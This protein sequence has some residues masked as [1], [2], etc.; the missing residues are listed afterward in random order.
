MIAVRIGPKLQTGSDRVPIVLQNPWGTQDA[1]RPT[2]HK[3][4][5]LR[6]RSF[7]R[8]L[9]LGIRKAG[10]EINVRVEGQV[11]LNSMPLVLSAVQAGSCIA[12]IMEDRAKALLEA[13]EAVRVMGSW[14][15]RSMV[16]TF[17]IRAAVSRRLLS[18][19]SS[20]RFATKVDNQKAFHGV[21]LEGGSSVG[22]AAIC[23]S[24]DHPHS[25]PRCRRVRLEAARQPLPIA[26]KPCLAAYSR[27]LFALSPSQVGFNRDAAR[28]RR[29][30]CFRLR[31]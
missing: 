22:A 31:F 11:T 25:K 16:I 7:S 2:K 8:A 26:S 4:I 24:G 12:Y 14:S 29:S 9:C 17:I 15:P 13:G 10:K 19:C 20:R 27:S 3:C 1:T 23:E 30:S 28:A 18:V 21:G 6:M 5:N